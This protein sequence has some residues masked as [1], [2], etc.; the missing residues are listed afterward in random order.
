MNKNTY[1]GLALAAGMA[2]ISASSFAA[3]LPDAPI[4]PSGP[5]PST[6][7][8]KGYAEFLKK[9]AEYYRD[10]AAYEDAVAKVY[11]D[12]GNSTLKAKHQ[13]LVTHERALAKEYELTGTEHDKAAA[14][15]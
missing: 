2:V 4:H 15:K 12:E 7:D 3:D 13:A 8:H 5:T 6:S 9:H 10:L 1:L 14:P 11:G